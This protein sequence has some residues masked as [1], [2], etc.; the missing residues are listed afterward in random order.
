MIEIPARL[1]VRESDQDL[2]ARVVRGKSPR[3][4]FA[5]TLQWSETSLFIASVSRMLEAAA[6]PTLATGLEVYRKRRIATQLDRIATQ[7]DALAAS[8]L[9]G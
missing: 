3:E 8:T 9:T 1:L 7:L 5:F 6:G 4:K 2:V